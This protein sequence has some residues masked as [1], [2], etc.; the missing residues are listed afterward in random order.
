MC[1]S[2]FVQYVVLKF[3]CK[4]LTFQIERNIIKVKSGSLTSI[5]KY[6]EKGHRQPGD[7]TLLHSLKPYDQK[8]IG[9]IKRKQKETGQLGAQLLD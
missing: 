4:L 6:G 5:T 8:V 7:F 2:F 9:Y 1:G 3:A